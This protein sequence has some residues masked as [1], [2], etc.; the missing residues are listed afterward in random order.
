MLNCCQ[1][2]R[3]KMCNYFHQSKPYIGFDFRLVQVIGLLVHSLATAYS[4]N[5][6]MLSVSGTTGALKCCQKQGF[7]T[8]DILQCQKQGFQNLSESLEEKSTFLTLLHSVLFGLFQLLLIHLQ[9]PVLAGRS[10]FYCT[11]TICNFWP[12]AW[13]PVILLHKTILCYCIKN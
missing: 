9:A 10:S 11:K 4:D 2:L 13:V 5:H 6:H 1:S 8:L 12:S 3:M 7:R